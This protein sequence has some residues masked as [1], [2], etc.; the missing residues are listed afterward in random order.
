MTTTERDVRVKKCFVW[1]ATLL[2]TIFALYPL[3]AQKKVY[4]TRWVNPNE[5]IID[6]RLDDPAWNAVAWADDFIQREPYEGK[7]P[8]QKTAFKIL[9]DNRNMYV[10]IQAYDNEPEKIDCRL[11]R[12]DNAEGDLVA[13]QLDSYQDHRTAFTFIVNA[14]G[15]KIDGIFTNDGEN[16]DYTYDPIWYVKTALNGEGWAAEMR[17]PLSQLRFGK[18]ENYIWGLQVA[19]YLYRK[20][21][22][23]CW[24]HIPKDSPGWVHLFGELHGISGITP[25]RRMELM[26]YTVGLTETQKKEENNPFVPGRSW[27]SN[28]GL[29]GKIGVTSDLT[30]DLTINPDFGQVEA[31]PSV[32]NLTAF[33]T[34][35]EEKRP[36]FIEG[37]NI[38]DYRI[39]LGDGDLAR[40]NLF[41]SRRIGKSASY[42]PETDDDEYVKMPE[43]SS[44]LG[45]MKLTGKTK[46]GVSIG[47]MDAVT[48]REQA[49]IDFYGQRREESVEPM[50]NYFL[51]R[52]QKDFNQGATTIGGIVTNTYRDIRDENLQFLNRNA[53]T[54]GFDFQHQWKK[55]TYYITLKTV[56]SRI[57]GTGEAILEQQQSSRRYFQRPDAKYVTLDSSRTSLSGYGGSLFFGKS[58]SGHV[59][60]VLGSTW[61]SPGLELNDMGYLRKADVILQFIWAGYRYWKPFSIFRTVNVN[62]NQWRG[63]YFGGENSSN[64]GNV[65]MGAQFKNYWSFGMGVG[66][67]G[68]G[69]STS[70]LRGGPAMLYAPQWN[71]WFYISSDS[72]KSFQFS[73]SVSNNRSTDNYSRYQNWGFGMTWRPNNAVS[74]SL[75]PFFTIN[76]D[77]LQYVDTIENG[78]NKYIFGRID[79]KTLGFVVRMNYSITPML[80]IQYYGQ[81]FVSA[82]KYTHFKRITQPRAKK[83]ADRFY[84]F[85]GEEIRYDSDEEEYTIDDDADGTVD[86]T[87]ENPNFNFREFRSNLVIRWE[88]SPGSTLYFVWSQG[89]T[90]DT[91]KNDFSFKND[92]RNLFHIYPHNVFLIKFNR[93]FSL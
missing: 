76:K 28:V 87:I 74:F 56:F 7:E 1:V 58:G 41:Y 89:R 8:S 36:F 83:Y 34:F 43:N 21:E 65:S 59:N 15:V 4:T 10:A 55:R 45:A 42:E 48:A 71:Y 86:Y 67:N 60:F 88:Y 33:E 22:L 11:S 40:D 68:E 64:G 84:T 82:G 24:Q 93:W 85:A 32:V 77:D 44:I 66:L 57:G 30:L 72:K 47:L 9:Y 5:P 12:K 6:G 54:G 78:E 35:Y 75:S 19:R 39:M 38:L 62:F 91:S 73:F 80:T 63:W 46:N 92:V 27:G 2:T 13:V 52:V 18:Q 25:S 79:Q 14:G 81:P 50:T 70:L 20:E 29:D 31:D 23:S 90:D 69:L 3:Y 17:T 37:N 16:E 49:V 26:P 51:G 61:R 53:F